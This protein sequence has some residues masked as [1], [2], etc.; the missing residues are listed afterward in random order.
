MVWCSVVILLP[1][2]VPW[3]AIG[4]SPS[5]WI[6]CRAC[7]SFGGGAVERQRPRNNVSLS[8]LA[9]DDADESTSESSEEVANDLGIEI[10]RGES[11]EIS[12]DTWL[13]IEDA[14]PDQMTVVKDLLG[15]NIFTYVLGALIIFFL[16]MK[17]LLG[18]GWLGQ[19]LGLGDVGTFTRVSD[20]LPL[21]VDVSGQDYLL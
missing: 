20:Q 7:R 18:P 3:Q 8:A 9:A 13:D 2:S 1:L 15:I 21:N 19:L 12:D 16:S 17:V 5:P 10:I 4:F 11:D 14:K 6:S